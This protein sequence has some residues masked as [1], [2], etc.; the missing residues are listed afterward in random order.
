MNNTLKIGISSILFSLLLASCSEGTQKPSSSLLKSTSSNFY[1]EKGILKCPNVEVGTQEPYFKDPSMT[2]IA[3]GDDDSKAP[4]KNY[5]NKNYALCTTSVTSMAG[6]Y[7]KSSI[8]IDKDTV[9]NDNEQ[10]KSEVKDDVTV[11]DTSNVTD[12][13]DMF[14]Y[15]YNFNQD[16]HNWDTSKVTNMSGMFY[17][18]RSFNQPIGNWSTSKVTNM[19]FMFMD[20]DIFYQDISEWN[21]ASEPTHIWFAKNSKLLDNPKYLP[22]FEG[23]KKGFYIESGTLKCPNV[24]VGTQEPYFKD[25]S[26]TVIAVGDDDSKAPIKNYIYNKDTMLKTMLC[27]THVTKMNR[28][29]MNVFV[30]YPPIGNWDTSRVTNMEQMFR[31]S[32][33]NQP[34]GN[35]DTSKV[36]SMREMFDDSSFNQPIGNW[37]T[38]KVTDMSGMFDNAS[39]F[40]QPIGNWDTSKVTD[41]SYMFYRASSFSQNINRWNVDKIININFREFMIYSKLDTHMTYWPHFGSVIINTLSKNRKTCD[42]GILSGLN[43]ANKPDIICANAENIAINPSEI[44]QVWNKTDSNWDWAVGYNKATCPGDDVAVGLGDWFDGTT[45]QCAPI[46]GAD[47]KQH[48]DT[49]NVLC[50]VEWI[51]HGDVNQLAKYDDVGEVYYDFAPYSYKFYMD[52]HSFIKG[53]ASKDHKIQA[54]LVC[55]IL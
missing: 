42:S 22:D 45:I 9:T 13:R 29:F 11:F 48:I 6:L 53:F 17:R 25:S 32:S 51:N 21:I 10:V 24:E 55:R 16:L 41:M 46:H 27:T 26:M 2:V 35:W 12:M 23:A 33:F 40:N 54:V 38:S 37:D 20:A 30:F 50:S 15:A 34:I 18:A 47:K 1:I 49:K 36:T 8:F 19:D 44:H 43:G 39:S 52:N 7:S 5:I 14:A 3:V 28:L 31:H 4:I